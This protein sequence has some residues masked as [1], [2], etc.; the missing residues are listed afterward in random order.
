[1]LVY[2]SILPSFVGHDRHHQRRQPIDREERVRLGSSRQ[3]LPDLSSDWFGHRSSSAKLY[4]DC[5]RCRYSH[6]RSRTRLANENGE[7]PCAREK[8]DGA[9]DVDAGRP[10][11]S[12]MAG[13]ST[14]MGEGAMVQNS[15]GR[16]SWRYCTI[17]RDLRRRYVDRVR[18]EE[19]LACCD[20]VRGE[21]NGQW[22]VKEICEAL[23]RKCI[24]SKR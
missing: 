2:T 3:Y 13:R 15:D 11:Y 24:F 21:D 7:K 8:A 5:P 22:N 10:S 17:M 6:S 23:R 19:D 20:A 14:E 9:V 16:G 4:V 18:T 1:M 12:P